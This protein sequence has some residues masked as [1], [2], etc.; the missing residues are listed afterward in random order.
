LSL[1]LLLSQCRSS[2]SDKVMVMSHGK[3]FVLDK[4]P[5]QA[6][7][8]VEGDAPALQTVVVHHDE[9]TEC[10]DF[11]FDSGAVVVP[12]KLRPQY[13]RAN[14]RWHSF[15]N[16]GWDNSTQKVDSL[17]SIRRQEA[18]LKLMRY[19]LYTVRVA[20]DSAFD[21]LFLL[22]GRTRD[23][24]VAGSAWDFNRRYRATVEAVGLEGRYLTVRVHKVVRL[25]DR[26]D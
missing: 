14:A 12:L 20:S 7:D 5:Q 8:T 24:T 10:G 15:I 16:R 17:T 19:R 1:L 13:T 23:D 2:K 26:K 4:S 18:K 11:E 21:S 3:I 25:A 6:A 9:C 22:P